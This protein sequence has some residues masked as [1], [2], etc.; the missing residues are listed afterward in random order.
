MK[1]VAI[2]ILDHK[3]GVREEKWEMINRI[4]RIFIGF[5]WDYL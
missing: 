3:F 5:E 2:G 4:G 1:E